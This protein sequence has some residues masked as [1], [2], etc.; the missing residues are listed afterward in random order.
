[1][2]EQARQPAEGGEAGQRANVWAGVRS[3]LRAV[4]PV[5]IRPNDIPVYLRARGLLR[6]VG[7]LS[8]LWVSTRSSSSR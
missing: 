8:R 6:R 1:M 4:A 5:R 3:P 7:A 2:T